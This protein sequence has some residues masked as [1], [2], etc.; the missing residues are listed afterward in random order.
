MAIGYT[1]FGLAPWMMRL[2]KSSNRPSQRL[3]QQSLQ[4]VE[5]AVTH[6]QLHL[7]Q[8]V[9]GMQPSTATGNW[10]WLSQPNNPINHFLGGSWRLLTLQKPCVQKSGN[11]SI[12]PNFRP[13]FSR[14][15]LLSTF[16][17][18]PQ[19]RQFPAPPGYSDSWLPPAAGYAAPR[20]PGAR[21]P[22]GSA[23]ATAAAAGSTSGWERPEGLGREGLDGG[24]LWGNGIENWGKYGEIMGM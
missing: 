21:H 4:R 17:A 11:P 18:R 13:R 5:H 8:V 9:K 24:N 14:A 12:S 1:P 20:L 3:F 16:E 22:T 19:S 10:E 2:K 7:N 15:V 23:E 6:V